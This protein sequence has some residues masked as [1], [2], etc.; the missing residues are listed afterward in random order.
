MPVGTSMRVAQLVKQ[1]DRLYLEGMDH[2]N[3]SDPRL[4]SD[5][6]AENRKALEIFK[7]SRDAYVSAQDEYTEG[8][9]PPSAL[10]DRTR[11]VLMRC[12]LC[13][14]RTLTPDRR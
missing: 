11:E 9:S 8:R 7:Q 14:K 4:T 6:A 3:K 2:L 1:G 10:L 5:W 12:H 13:R